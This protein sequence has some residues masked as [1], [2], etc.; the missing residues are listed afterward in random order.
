MSEVKH[1]DY[2]GFTFGD[3][4]SSQLGIVRTSEGSRFNESLL[5]TLQDKTIQVP[6]GDGTY[7]FG[8]FYTQ[9]SINI[10]FAFDSL[11]EQQL[12]ELKTWLGDKKIRNLILDEAPYKAYHAKI[13]GSA[14]IKHIPFAEGA[15]NRT[16][17]GEGSIQ[18]TAYDPYAYSVHKYLNEYN[19]FNIEEWR[20]AADLLEQQYDYDKISDTNKI[21]LYNN[22][23]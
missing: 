2:V 22:F 8:S 1:I 19:C 11:T 9:K 3:K 5:P 14:T 7:L 12:N 20:D 16:Y 13:T 23:R 6:G 18:F 15:T 4:H 21:K 10:S 17:K